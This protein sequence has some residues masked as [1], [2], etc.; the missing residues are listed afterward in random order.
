MLPF[1][2]G[3]MMRVTG[4]QRRAAM[5]VGAA[6]TLSSLAACG[7]G[8]GGSTPG[9]APLS[10]TSGSASASSSS[11]S[12]PATSA[13][14]NSGTPAEA[15][16]AGQ[17]AVAAYRAAFAD[18]QTAGATSNYQDPV[19]THHMSGQAL[20]YVSGALRVD[21]VQGSVSKG[22][23]VLHPTIGQLIPPN[24]PTE[25]VINDVIDT[26]PWLQYTTDGHLY[27]DTPGGCRQTQ[28]LVVKKDGVWKVDQF[29]INKVGTG[30]C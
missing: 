5:L 27:N 22:A 13:P 12:A 1:Y 3:S 15:A 23:P 4:L 19:L 7:G 21:Q 30:K 20:S 10:G 16:Q 24:D 17:D 8:G 18:W 14:S 26:R 9:A 2:G 11:T 29:A 28:A 6:L 25:V